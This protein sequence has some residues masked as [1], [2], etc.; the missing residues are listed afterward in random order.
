MFATLVAL[1]SAYIENEAAWDAIVPLALS[2]YATAAA[3]SSRTC[4]TSSATC[5]TS[6]AALSAILS[7]SCALLIATDT[8]MGDGCVAA[9]GRL[10]MYPTPFA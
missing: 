9:L 5:L 4:Q 3:T 2:I 7:A 8:P 6:D 1:A 10:S